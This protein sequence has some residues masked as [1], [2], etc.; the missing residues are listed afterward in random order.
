L[1]NVGNNTSSKIS[2]YFFQWLPQIRAY[3]LTDG[4]T[5]GQTGTTNLTGV[6]IFS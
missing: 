5:D 6:C 3:K 1:S 2:V 4:R